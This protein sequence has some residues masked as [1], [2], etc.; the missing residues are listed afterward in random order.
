MSPIDS[1]AIPSKEVLLRAQSQWLFTSAELLRTPSILDGLSPAQEHSNRSKGVNFITQVGILLKLPQITLATASVYLH[2][3]Y[4]RHSMVDLPSRPGLHHYAIAA[5]SLFLATKVEENCRKMKELVV[6]CC[7]VAQKQ[8]N[9]VVDEQNKEYWRWRDTILVNE[10]L[11]LESLCFDLQLEHPHRLLF[12]ILCYYNVQD[13]KHLRNAAWAFVND[14]NLTTLCLLFP[15]RT[16]AAAALYAAAKHTD[17]AFPDDEWGRPW[18][19]QLSF[20]IVELRKACS[21]LAEA[22]EENPLPRQGE[23]GL[24]AREEDDMDENGAKTRSSPL[25]TTTSTNGNVQSGALEDERP[26]SMSEGSEEGE[27]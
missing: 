21:V 16:I 20:D 18:W 11:L 7:R 4:V 25:T 17:V 9:L 3:F 24:Y 22:Y 15:A 1:V 26:V 27:V 14:S 6:A 12:D 23:K 5:T 2:R 10:D 13:N 19:E 8:P